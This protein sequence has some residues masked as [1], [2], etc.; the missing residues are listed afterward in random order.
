MKKTQLWN[1]LLAA[2]ALVLSVCAGM[3]GWLRNLPQKGTGYLPAAL[4]CVL[5]AVFFVA[6]LRLAPRAQ[7][8]RCYRLFSRADALLLGAALTVSACVTDVSA[9]LD[10]NALFKTVGILLPAAAILSAL[11][12]FAAFFTKKANFVT[13]GVAAL[14]LFC[15]LRIVVSTAGV[16]SQ[17]DVL[18]YLPH[19]LTCLCVGVSVWKLYEVSRKNGKGLQLLTAASALGVCACVADF[20]FWVIYR[21]NTFGTLS[22]GQ[23]VFD[24]SFGAFLAWLTVTLPRRPKIAEEEAACSN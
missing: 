2:C 8:G 23:A 3:G 15:S 24:G 16:F 5:A 21:E 20:V 9:L 12:F 19:L 18:L 10:G 7:E 22:V 11:A 14:E 13:A 6:F 1:W 17:P 4:F